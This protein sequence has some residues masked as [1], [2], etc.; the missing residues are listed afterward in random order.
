M[1][2]RTDERDWQRIRE[3]FA[4]AGELSAVEREAFLDRELA[5]EPT[6]RAELTNLFAAEASATEF[7]TSSK[8]DPIQRTIG[9]YRLVKLLG[10]GGFGIVY[11]AEQDRPL[12]RRVALK[13][14][15]PGMDT[16][17][18]I[19]RFNA[20]RQALA[21]MDHPGIAQVHDAGETETGRP[22]F[23]M[24]YV[25]GIPITAFCD[26]ST[27]RVRDRLELF[28]EV[29]DA[30]QHAHQKGLIHR[31]IKPSNV[32]VTRR[33]GVAIPKVIDFGIAKA[34]GAG[35][36]DRTIATHEGVIL[37]TLGSMSPEQAGA[38]EA[39]VD[40]RS[41]I[42]SLGVLLYEL[43]TGQPPFDSA[44]LRQASWSEAV[45]MI[46]EETPPAPS[47]R[48]ASQ[49]DDTDAPRCRGVERRELL[50]ELK[51]DLDWITMRA[52][53]K[54][55]GR[56][57][58]SASEL[59]A[60]IRRHLQG[61]PVLAGAPST[62]YRLRKFVRRH[63]AGVLAGSLVLLAL[64][65]GGVATGIGFRRALRAEKAARR[66]AASAEQV[67]AFLV[68]LFRT[69][70]PDRLR[71]ETVTARTPR[72]WSAAHPRESSRTTPRFAHCS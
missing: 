59:A 1:T 22:Y 41:D 17:Q 7:L 47:T 49:P 30:I 66:E 67:S 2:D 54:E 35:L 56:R 28:L 10:E 15:K 14:I 21:F 64:L 26:E 12:R 62:G 32:L 34:T 38:I 27:L 43:L 18:V 68:D 39:V 60:D 44:Q 48:I 16:R 55:P 11:L 24:E 13:L 46:R 40:T 50:R 37:G 33:D 23:V 52:L 58:A 25:Q 5:N 3:L 65:V 42:Y 29:C 61:Q 8:T 51:G 6:M 69:A 70:S 20:E 9:P 72:R 53:E 36:A 71:R 19:A 45:R 31:D 4:A 57:Y 63:R